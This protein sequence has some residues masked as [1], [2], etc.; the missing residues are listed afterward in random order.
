LLARIESRPSESE[1]RCEQ[2][3]AAVQGG[4]TPSLHSRIE[5][6]QTPKGRRATPKVWK[7]RASAG[8]SQRAPLY[9]QRFKEKKLKDQWGV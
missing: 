6:P 9:R 5:L 7:L 8:D 4:A 1:R 2:E 3:D